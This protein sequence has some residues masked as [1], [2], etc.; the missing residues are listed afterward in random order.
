M[1]NF[2]FKAKIGRERTQR[3]QAAT[4][5]IEPRIARIARMGNGFG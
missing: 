1:Q 3:G 2:V 4:K 5:G